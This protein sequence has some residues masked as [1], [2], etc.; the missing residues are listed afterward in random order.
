ML[1]DDDAKEWSETLCVS[2][3][4]YF[5][6]EEK[7]NGMSRAYLRSTEWHRKSAKIDRRMAAATTSNGTSILI[8]FLS[9]WEIKCDKKSLSRN[10]NG[11]SGTDVNIECTRHT[12]T[13]W[14]TLMPRLN[15]INIAFKL[16]RF[17]TNNDAMIVMHIAHGSHYIGIIK[18]DLF[19]LLVIGLAAREFFLLRLH[20]WNHYW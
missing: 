2:A 13:E 20:Y 3:I 12:T 6:N 9:T 19:S 7:K 8:L 11:N 4:A 10:D 15:V 14:L 18:I 17:R 1:N 16:L 5:G